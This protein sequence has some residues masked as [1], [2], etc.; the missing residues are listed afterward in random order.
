[1]VLLLFLNLG[2]FSSLFACLFCTLSCGFD[3]VVVGLRA[4]DLTE[5]SDV[6]CLLLGRKLLKRLL[7]QVALLLSETDPGTV[8]NS[9][10][11]EQILDATSGRRFRWRLFFIIPGRR[12]GEQRLRLLDVLVQVLGL[13]SIVTI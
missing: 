3:N 8:E 2:L 7:K 6:G 4:P 1:M 11:G 10:V 13:A 5:E 12:L 9:V